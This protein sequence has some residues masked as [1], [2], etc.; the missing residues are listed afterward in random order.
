[1]T[2]FY[3]VRHGEPNWF[4]KDQRNLK[5]ALRDFVPLTDNGVYQAEQVLPN[6]K[7]L[8]N[9]DL[10]LS[11]PYTRSLQTA[12]IINTKIGL[13][14][15]VEYDLHEWTPDN[16]QAS[17]LDEIT[18]LWKDFLKHN[19]IY[20]EDGRKLWES[21]QSVVNRVRKVLSGYLDKSNII[22]VCHGMVIASL[23]E[24]S[25]EEIQLCGVYEYELT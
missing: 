4:L 21:K 11:S 20:P 18:E 12:A 16:W 8:L 25:S 13:P 19:G 3:L 1:M 9:C 5:G 24:L 15:K 17:G 6:H 7:Y 14:L 22:V 2:I 10:I 23:L